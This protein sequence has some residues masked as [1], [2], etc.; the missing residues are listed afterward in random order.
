MFFCFIAYSTKNR[1]KI[2]KNTTIDNQQ[3]I[4]KMHF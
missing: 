2:A 3:V 4:K 1:Q